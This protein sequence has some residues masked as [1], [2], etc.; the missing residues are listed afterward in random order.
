MIQQNPKNFQEDDDYYIDQIS[1]KRLARIWG[2]FPWW[3]G[4]NV[5]FVKFQVLSEENERRIISFISNRPTI[6]SFID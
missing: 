5:P 4:A 3:C 2:L 1:Q 6:H